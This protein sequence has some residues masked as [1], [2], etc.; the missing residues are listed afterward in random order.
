M[1]HKAETRQVRVMRAT[2]PAELEAAC[3]ERDRLE[4]ERD[5][6]HAIA[7]ERAGEIVR[8]RGLLNERTE[9]STRS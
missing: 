5:M 4:A 7:D 9:S 2:L 8:L 1:G 6:W 3:A